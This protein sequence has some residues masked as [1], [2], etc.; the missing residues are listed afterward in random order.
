MTVFKTSI[1]FL[2]LF[3]FVG[4]FF[5]KSEDSDSIYYNE[6]FGFK[7]FKPDGWHVETSKEYVETLRKIDLNDPKLKDIVQKNANVPVV[8]YTKYREPYQDLNPGF[9]V[10][11]YP[12]GKFDPKQPVKILD[13]LLPNL[14]RVLKDYRLVIPPR[15]TTV[16]GLKASYMQ[17]F[18]TLVTSD[19][20]RYPSCTEIWVVP[21][22]NYF[23]ALGA[24]TR[25]DERNCARKD[26]GRI[27]E[28]M[29]I[30]K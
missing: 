17:V 27:V 14:Q 23:L 11:V 16:S 26:V 18:Y 29:V 10:N 3:L 24:V 5:C 21:N 15:E 20:S 13:V 19:G 8:S 30:D 25:Q 1:P 22:K 7:V 28:T 12:L 6:T 9:K 2:L 4:G